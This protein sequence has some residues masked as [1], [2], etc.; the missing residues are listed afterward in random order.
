MSLLSETKTTVAQANTL[1]ATETTSLGTSS[2]LGF[3]ISSGQL[4]QKVGLC[5]LGSSEYAPVIDLATGQPMELPQGYIPML[6]FF[7]AEETLN[8]NTIGFLVSTSPTSF[9]DMYDISDFNGTYINYK[10]MYNFAGTWLGSDFIGRN[11]FCLVNY[12]YPTVT[13]GV[14]KAYFLFT[15]P[16]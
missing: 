10:V 4:K 1:Q 2:T 12:S 5:T 13:T 16:N 3:P 14:V 15:T 6:I 11:F 9:V 7:S 8:N